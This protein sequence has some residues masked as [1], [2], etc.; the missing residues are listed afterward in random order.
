MSNAFVQNLT[1]QL[2]SLI[3]T[4]KEHLTNEIRQRKFG[5]VKEALGTGR[6]EPSL[7]Q[8]LINS[9]CIIQFS[10]VYFTRDFSYVFG[11]FQLNSLCN[12]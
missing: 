3:Y 11:V 7:Q 10:S 4:A 12:Y 8:H 1:S 6:N 9:V 2:L 5:R